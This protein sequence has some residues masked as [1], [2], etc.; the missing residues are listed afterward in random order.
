MSTTGGGE[1][2]TT[3]AWR[4]GMKNPY[5][6]ECTLT[7]F[8]KPR[9]RMSRRAS[10]CRIVD[11]LSRSPVTGCNSG[12]LST[13]QSRGLLLSPELRCGAESGSPFWTAHSMINTELLATCTMLWSPRQIPKVAKADSIT[14]ATLMKGKS[15]GKVESHEEAPFSWA[16]SIART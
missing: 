13:P 14:K 15:R 4:V 11:G 16:S 12:S 8:P 3:V 10:P 6:E 7:A 5:V 1:R 9:A 2:G